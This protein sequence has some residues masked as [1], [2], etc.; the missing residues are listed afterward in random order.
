MKVSAIK[1]GASSSLY[2]SV[3]FTSEELFKMCGHGTV[4]RDWKGTIRKQDDNWFSVKVGKEGASTV[5]IGTS[6]SNTSDPTRTVGFLKIMASQVELSPPQISSMP[7]AQCEIHGSALWFK[8]PS[9]FYQKTTFDG[10]RT[11]D[12]TDMVE[13]DPIQALKVAIGQVNTVCQQI[14]NKGLSEV[15]LKLVPI[16]ADKPQGLKTLKASVVQA[17]EI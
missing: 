15:E 4:P 1:G 2:L 3:Y 9:V 5:G 17:V 16:D 13:H 7:P 11:M 8:L 12:F 6:A 14:A 10:K